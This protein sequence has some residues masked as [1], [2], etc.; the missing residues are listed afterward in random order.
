MLT[1]QQNVLVWNCFNHAISV[2]WSVQEKYS[3]APPCSPL[4][5]VWSLTFRIPYIKEGGNGTMACFTQIETWIS[6]KLYCLLSSI[7]WV[8]LTIHGR[9][10]CSVSHTCKHIIYSVY[11]E[12]LIT[13]TILY[14]NTY[15]NHT[16]GLIN[17]ILSIRYYNQ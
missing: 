16:S 14:I 13:T 5:S 9:V 15:N 1:S 17:Y 6:D 11:L 7:Y 4:V 3:S 12:W 8:P 2:P 10:I